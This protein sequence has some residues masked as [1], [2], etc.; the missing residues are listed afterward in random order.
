[1]RAD[2]EF[3]IVAAWLPAAVVTL[4]VLAELVALPFL[5]GTI[6][7]H[8][9]LAGEP[10]GT[11]PAWTVVAATAGTGYGITAL[12]AVLSRFDLRS[13][14]DDPAPRF[15]VGATWFGVQVGSV[16]PAAL[17]LAQVA[18]GAPAAGPSLAVALATGGAAAIAAGSLVRVPARADGSATDPRQLTRTT[19]AAR[20][21]AQ[22]ALVA[23]TLT[24]FTIAAH[25]F[26]AAGSASWIVA[27]ALSVVN[28]LGAASQLVVVVRIDARGVLV[29]SP[30]GVP[31]VRIPLA[32]IAG[33][34]VVQVD[35]VADI[36]R[37]GWNTRVAGPQAGVAIRAGEG[38]RIDRADGTRFVVATDGADGGA[39]VLAAQAAAERDRAMNSA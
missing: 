26:A 17:T 5:P 11:A 25:A 37:L 30:I 23:G 13:L 31:R 38:I 19:V 9:S 3:W 20:S 4:A 12:F 32:D 28:A 39:R 2:R 34:R 29:R 24:L 14:R 27:A 33:A 22:T 16:L 35:P 36:G 1:M 8:W 18:D 6:V 7:T 10:D 15:L 21:G